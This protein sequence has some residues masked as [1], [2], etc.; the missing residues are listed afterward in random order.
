LRG[1]IL[2]A[3]LA[4]AMSTLSS[5]LNSSA[6]SLVNDW[7]GNWLTGVDQRRALRLA[8]WLTLVFAA[9][10]AAVAIAAYERGLDKAIVMAVLV[11]AGFATGL[12]LGLYGLGLVAPKTSEPVAIIAFAVGTVVTCW[13]AY[14]TQLNGLWYTLVGSTTIV[15][16]GLILGP[17]VPAARA[18]TTP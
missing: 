5:S 15:V 3:V 8:R 9:V 13:V 18:S 6:S 17:L 2:A 11:I 16:V 7:L 4:A 10:Q 12:L 14:A 1:L